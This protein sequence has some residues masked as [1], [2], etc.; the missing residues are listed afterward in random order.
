MTAATSRYS[1][2]V[3]ENIGTTGFGTSNLLRYRWHIR[4]K[5]GQIVKSGYSLTATLADMDARNQC[6]RLERKGGTWLER[7]LARKARRESR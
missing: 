5:A 2:E 4:N 7:A 6:E 3:T 1:Y